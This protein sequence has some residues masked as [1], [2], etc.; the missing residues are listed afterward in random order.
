M[1]RAVIVDDERLAIRAV[2][3]LLAAHPEVTVAGTAE[4]LDEAVAVIAAQRPDVVFL[5]VDLGGGDGFDVIARLSPVPRIVFVTAHPQFAVEAFAVAAVD[6]LLKPIEPARMA[7]ALA[8]LA[9]LSQTAREGNAPPIELRTPRRTVF[10]DPAAIVALLAEG[11]F[12]RVVLA[13]QPGLLILRTLGQFEALLPAASF[14]RVSRSAIL[15]LD[16]VRRLETRDR[17]GAE[18][19]LEGLEDSLPLGRGATA[20]L[21]AALAARAG[22]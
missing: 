3:R 22:A 12:T 1:L 11:D 13:G 5:D 8:R 20:R 7:E 15:N 21:R 17:N 16:R 14:L 2:V 9:R 18:V 19:V 10:A 6:Y 4:T